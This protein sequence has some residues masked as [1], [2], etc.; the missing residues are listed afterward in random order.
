MRS[1]STRKGKNDKNKQINKNN[2]VLIIVMSRKYIK[3]DALGVKEKKFRSVHLNA[4]YNSRQY[5][6]PPKK[7]RRKYDAR[8]NE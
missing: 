3:W 2:C 4:K 6:P 7:K 1:I 5:Y 8:K